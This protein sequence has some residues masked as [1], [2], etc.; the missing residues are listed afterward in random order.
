MEFVASGQIREG[1]CVAE[2]VTDPQG[3]TLIARGQRIGFHH[4]VRL[5]KFGIQSLFIDP[6]N[7]EGVAK[8]G[9]SEIRKQCE[10]VL[11][12]SC[13]KL[14]Q[15][16]AAKRINLDGAAIRAAMENLVESL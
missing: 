11:S 16:F 2:D 4:I 10:A 6:K 13:A 7:G 14:T 9:K 1:M 8:P 3:R 5:R 12:A 15:E